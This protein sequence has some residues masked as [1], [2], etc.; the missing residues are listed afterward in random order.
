MLARFLIIAVVKQEKNH[1]PSS[2]AADAEEDGSA[3]KPL[4]VAVPLCLGVEKNRFTNI[5]SDPVHKTLSI[6]VVVVD[7]RRSKEDEEA[8]GKDVGNSGPKPQEIVSHSEN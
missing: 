7:A 6:L 8:G 2:I 5:P 3:K 1:T 4:T